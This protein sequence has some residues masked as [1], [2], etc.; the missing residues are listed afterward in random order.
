AVTSIEDG[1]TSNVETFTYDAKGNML[2]HFNPAGEN[3]TMLWDESN[4]LKAVNVADAI[5]HHYV[6]DVSGTR[7]LKGK[8]DITDLRVDGQPQLPFEAKI[9]NYTLYPSAGRRM[10]RGQARREITL[11]Q[12]EAALKGISARL[13]SEVL[14]ESPAAYKDIDQ[15]MAAQTDLVDVVHSLRQVVNVKG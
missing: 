11:E 4:M 10:S 2:T 7:V 5:L 13:D 15:V 14:D 3:K 12:H 8:G 1:L 6:Y 9:G